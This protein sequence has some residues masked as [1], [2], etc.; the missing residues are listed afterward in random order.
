MRCDPSRW[1]AR[2]TTIASRVVPAIGDTMA[3]SRG[4]AGALLEAIGRARVEEAIPV[5]VWLAAAERA[6]I[7]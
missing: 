3:T 1:D 5:S 6:A 7:A 2:Q 4:L